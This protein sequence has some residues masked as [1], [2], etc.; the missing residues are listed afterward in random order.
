MVQPAEVE[1]LTAGTLRTLGQK[2]LVAQQRLQQRRIYLP[3]GGPGTVLVIAQI[4]LRLNPG[5]EQDI[6][7]AAIETRHRAIGLDQT[8]VAEPADVE[9]C[10]VFLVVIEQR[11]V[12]GRD[13]GCALASCCDVTT[14]EV[15]DDRDFGQLGQ[16]RRVADLDAETACRLVADSLTVAADCSDLA[17]DHVLFFQQLQNTL[18]NQMAPLLLGN[19]RARQLIRATGAETQQF[20]MQVFRHGNVVGC[21]KSWSVV[22]LQ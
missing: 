20:R 19:C 8:Q 21:Q 4:A 11:F 3:A 12:E 17:G 13:Q 9:Y 14:A 16:Q 15:T 2:E 5:I 10:A 7:R 1:H 6:A 18:G 22:L